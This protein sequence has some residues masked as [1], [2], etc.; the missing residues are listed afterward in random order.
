VH[1]ANT[2]F[3]FFLDGTHI[4]WKS[5]DK[6]NF[7]MC[8]TLTSGINGGYLGDY[9]DTKVALVAFNLSLY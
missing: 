7:R 8:A 6:I 2:S 3:T 4:L 9:D 1:L 5:G